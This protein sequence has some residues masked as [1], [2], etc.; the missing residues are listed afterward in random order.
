MHH[1][2]LRTPVEF[3]NVGYVYTIKNGSS[4][5]FTDLSDITTIKDTAS[6]ML[7]DGMFTVILDVRLMLPENETFSVRAD[8]KHAHITVRTATLKKHL[9]VVCRFSGP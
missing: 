3:Q 7:S 4:Y 5:G 9:N 6:G 1:T 8:N 2:L